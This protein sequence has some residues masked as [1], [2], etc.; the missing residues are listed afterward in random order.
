[1]TAILSTDPQPVIGWEATREEWLDARS[2]G[3]G[4]SDIAS[5]LGFSGYDTPYEVWVEKTGGRPFEESQSAAAR[6]G[7]D[8]EPWLLSQAAVIL[9]RPVE[10]TPARLYRD[11][12][13]RWRMA[14]PDGAVDGLAELVECKTAG[15]ASGYGAPAGWTEDSIP[16]AYELQARWQMSVMLAD[17]VHVVGLVAGMGVVHHVV[18]R[19]LGIEAELLAQV[20]QWWR[21]HVVEGVEP[22]L[23]AGDNA[24]LKA[25]YPH[26]TAA[27]IDLDGTEAAEIVARY[28]KHRTAE[29]DA[30]KAK[31]AEGVL[32]KAL[33][34]EH[35]VGLLDGRP[36][37]TW[38]EQRNTVDWQRMVLDLAAEH[39]FDLPDPETYRRPAKRVLGVK[40]EL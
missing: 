3:L 18:E 5:V 36:I 35:A 29:S 39:G 38:D 16:L 21:Q 15:I 8:L 26:P 4:A 28:R 11:P 24:I 12:V 2:A 6:L 9:G 10:R 7:D 25:L 1:M 40:E 34:K 33:L 14:S 22:P 30:K 32:L 23:G 19:D 37:V 27:E 31:E 13:R 20:G 17:R